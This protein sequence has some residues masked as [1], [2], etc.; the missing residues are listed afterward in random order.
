MSFLTDYH[1]NKG[2][3]VK[4]DNFN[5]PTQVYRLRYNNLFLD[6]GKSRDIVALHVL[7]DQK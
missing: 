7:L 4:T 1:L 2:L 3:Q 5:L 6:F